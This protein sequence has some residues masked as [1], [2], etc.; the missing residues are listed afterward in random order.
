MSM[1]LGC[2][3]NQ[4][5]LPVGAIPASGVPTGQQEGDHRSGTQPCNHWL[6]PAKEPAQ[7]RRSRWRLFDRIDSDGLMRYFVRRLEKLGHKVT[8][9]PIKPANQLLLIN[10]FEGEGRSD[11]R[12]A[13]EKGEAAMKI[14]AVATKS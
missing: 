9:V 6:L 11:A 12:E 13:Q 7:L 1:C 10:V 3:A 2:S 14:S 5:H 4:E 8:L